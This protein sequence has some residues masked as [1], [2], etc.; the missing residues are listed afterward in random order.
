MSGRTASTPGS[1]PRGRR[2]RPC[3]RRAIAGCARGR[4]RRGRGS[5]RSRRR[6]RAAR[7]R[8]RPCIVSATAVAAAPKCTSPALIARDEPSAARTISR[9]SSSIVS[10]VPR[11]TRSPTL[12]AIGAPS[13]AA[14]SSQWPR[15]AAKPRP[16]S[17]SASCSTQASASAVKSVSA[18]IIERRARRARSPD[19]ASLRRMQHV[20][21]DPD[22][23]VAPASGRVTASS[24]MPATLAPSTRTSFGHLRLARRSALCAPSSAMLSRSEGGRADRFASSARPGDEAERRRCGAAPCG[25]TRSRLAAR[26]PRRRL[27]GAAAAAMAGRLLAGDDPEPAGIAR[28]RPVERL[29][30]GRADRLEGREPIAGG[31]RLRARAQRPC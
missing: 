13:P 9:P 4:S 20:D 28:R 7:R 27:P 12:T 2:R 31:E 8:V 10:K 16:S 6:R 14:R 1:R 25:W 3:R 23:D 19:R 17:Q 30:A 29:R 21:A 26:L 22:H 24:R 11:Q 18:V 15:I 5:C